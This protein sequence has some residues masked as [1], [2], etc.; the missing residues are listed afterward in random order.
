MNI[1]ERD[2]M[3]ENEDFEIDNLLENS[4]LFK[5]ITD[6]LGF[7]HSIKEEKEIKQ[8]LATKKVQLKNNLENRAKALNMRSTQVEAKT[9][10]M[11]EL[12]PFYNETSVDTAVKLNLNKKEN[13]IVETSVEKRFLAWAID[14]CVISS[15]LT[16]CV[17]GIVFIAD[18]PLSFLRVN[19]LET[20]ILVISGLLSTM[21][22]MFYFTFLEKTDFSTLGK[23]VLNLKVVRGNGEPI[24]MLQSFTRSLLTLISLLTLGFG[25][26]LKIQD[27]LTDSIVQE[28]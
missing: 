26:V 6:G 3:I 16:I 15:L 5:P 23:R 24:S 2:K 25:S 17:I 19:L 13:L 22:Y 4:D 10:N 18:V 11:G 8:D 21:F 20:D 12:A 9:L 1:I 7:H 28:K 14:L 27:K